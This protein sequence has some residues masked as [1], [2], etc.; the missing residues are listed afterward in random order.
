M[1]EAVGVRSGQEQQ[2]F[3]SCLLL[4]RRKALAEN[5]ERDDGTRHLGALSGL[6]VVELADEKAEYCGM[7]LAGLGADVIKIEPPDGSPT[8]RIGP[9]F[10]DIQD[11]ERSLFF[12]HYNRG[13]KGIVL[14][15][16]QR[17]DRDRFLS[18]LSTADVF[19]ESTPKGELDA[20][21]LGAG[22]LTR[23][24]PTLIIAR[25]TSFGDDGPWADFKGSDLVHLALGGAMMNC[26][27]DTE[28]GGRYDLPPIAPQMWHSYH[29]AGEQMAMAI[30]ASLLYRWRTGKGQRLSCAIHEAVSKA[31]EVDL[32]SWVMRRAPVLRQTCRHAK[33]AV[34]RVP[35]ITYTKDGRWVMAHLGA[36]SNEGARLVAFLDKYGMAADLRPEEAS[37]QTSSRAVPGTAPDDENRSHT[38]EVI[39][40]FVRAFTYES[41]PWREAQEAGLLW[42]PLRKPHENA[43]DEHWLARGS[44]SDVEHPEL[45][46]SFR[47]PTS[48]W[49][50]T[51]NTWSPGRRAPLLN[52]D[53]RA[54]TEPPQRESPVISSSPQADHPVLFSPRGK[55]FPLKGIRILD[56]G[57]FLA[58]AGGT[59]FLAAMGAESIKVE[60]KSHPDT[61][62][63]AMAPQGGREARMKATSP[64]PGVKDPN[65]G[66]Q[67]N[68][69]NPGKRGI[70]LNVRHPKGLE[71]AKRLV[72]MSD[73]V[74]EGFSPGVMDK[75]GLGYESL[76]SIKPDII[77]AQQSGFGA[78]GRYGRL[79]AIGPIANSFAGLSDMSGLPEPAMPAGW[80]YSYLDWLGAY[81]F[82]LAM[83][84]ALFHRERTGEGQWIDASQ[85]EAGLFVNG[86]AVLDWAANGRV[87]SRYGNRSP[88]KPAAP[89][90][91]YRCSGEDRWVAIACFTEEEWQALVA[92]A[93]HPEWANDPR[94]GTLQSR[95][96][97]QDALDRLV[98]GWTQNL[99]AYDAMKRLQAAGVPA[100]VCQ[101]AEDRCE[102]DPQ[103]AHLEWLTEVTG[104]KIGRWPVAEVPVKM[105]ESPAYVGGRIDRG[106]P[107]YGEDNEYVYGELLGMSS[108]EIEELVAEGAI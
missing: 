35:T 57:W 36:L 42:S 84:S 76:R 104:T 90:G 64:L 31:T 94:F 81:S 29:I 2:A 89:H 12:W 102:H 99:E 101:T 93:G 6:R 56:F 87:W 91:A 15:L 37:V 48:K 92:V 38:M 8:R 103:L 83:L 39:Q 4:F 9:F 67:F 68:N 74:A 18:L 32:M 62:M 75:W 107:C 63:A 27:Y 70:S 100:G 3:L 105:S 21:G 16:H 14:D 77:Y 58:S 54:A 28:P 33:E 82:S 98:E 59:R 10:E 20:L 24:F 45:G 96:A 34:S 85:C 88:Y 5:S 40:R 17:G 41:I 51:A 52:E 47:Y 19:L 50:S 44:Y 23:R 25:M 106:A 30:V 61:R 69:K 65:M 55:P 11:P 49:L 97:N 53:A 73:I 79:R 22:E 60:L 80:G 1:P 78:R 72:A 108:K 26:G 71:I 86:T 66:G 46:R 7:E 13:K 43:L 95:L